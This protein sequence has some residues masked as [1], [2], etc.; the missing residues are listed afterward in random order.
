[1]K[2]FKNEKLLCLKMKYLILNFYNRR[3]N[4]INNLLIILIKCKNFSNIKKIY[5]KLGNH[6]L[7]IFHFY[8]YFQFSVSVLGFSVSVFSLKKF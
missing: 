4:F 6:T 8:S 2:D 7:E 1:M 5:L 3:N